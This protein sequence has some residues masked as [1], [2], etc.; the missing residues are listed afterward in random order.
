[1]AA[2]GGHRSWGMSRTVARGRHPTGTVSTGADKR[3]DCSGDG[4]QAPRTAGSTSRTPSAEPAAHPSSCLS[5][6]F[7]PTPL[8]FTP[9]RDRLGTLALSSHP[10][11]LSRV[12]D[13]MRVFAG[14]LGC[15]PGELEAYLDDG[16]LIRTSHMARHVF[17]ERPRE[18]WRSLRER[19]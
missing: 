11:D 10:E 15:R 3:G 2:G 7:A 18:L 13:G 8:R 12:V 9:I 14:Y 17:T 16:E 4:H 1:M 19:P 5:R 6:P